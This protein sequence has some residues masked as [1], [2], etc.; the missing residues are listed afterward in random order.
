MTTAAL[1]KKDIYYRLAYTFIGL[2]HYHHGRKHD[3][4]HIDMVLEVMMILELVPP[5]A[6]DCA[7]HCGLLNYKRPQSPSLQWHTFSNNTHL[8]QQGHTF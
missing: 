8:L 6:G 2:F 4:V 3:S 7:P 1:R 5:A